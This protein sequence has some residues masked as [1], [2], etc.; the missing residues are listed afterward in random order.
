MPPSMLSLCER[1]NFLTNPSSYSTKLDSADMFLRSD[2]NCFEDVL[3]LVHRIW[4]TLIYSLLKV[5]SC[6]VLC[7]FL[8]EVTVDRWTDRQI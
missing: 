6:R 7:F 4:W 1:S 8:C 3:L 2:I 5:R